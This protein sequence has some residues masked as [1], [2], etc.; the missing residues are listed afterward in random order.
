MRRFPILFAALLTLVVPSV[1]AHPVRADFLVAID[2]VLGSRS[3]RTVQLAWQAP[4]GA[5]SPEPQN[6]TAT[7]GT[8]KA[9]GPVVDP[10]PEREPNNTLATAQPVS[11]PILVTGQISTSDT[12]GPEIVYGDGTHDAIEDLYNLTLRPQ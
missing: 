1:L 11:I 4:I 12:G 6:L 5:Q 10:I 7:E 8:G 3:G 2:A 9:A